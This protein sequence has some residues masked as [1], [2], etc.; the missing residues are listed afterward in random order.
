MKRS[1]FRILVRALALILTLI[2][3]QRLY[4]L[5]LSQSP[6]FLA[7]QAAPIVM[8]S[9]SADNELF[10]KAY[11]DYSNLDGGPLTM[12]DTTYRNDFTYYGYFDPDWCYTYNSYGSDPDE[13]FIPANVTT[14][15]ICSATGSSTTVAAWSGNFL[16]WASMTRI[17]I[18]RQVLY[19]GMRSVDGTSSTILERSY[20][21]KDIHA[22]VKVYEGADVGNYTPY[23]DTQ[24]SLCNVSSDTNGHP[25]IRV[26]TGKWRQWA[27]AESVQCQWN[28]A[29]SDSTPSNST[30]CA[31]ENGTCSFTGTRLVAYGASGQYSW[32]T[33]TGSIACNNATFGDPIPGTYKRCYYA[34]SASTSQRPETTHEL[35]EVTARV[36]VCDAA[37]DGLTSDRCQQY[38]ESPATYKPVGVL[39]VHGEGG[40]IKFGLATGSYKANIK[41]GV[42]R[43]A[44]KLFANNDNSSEDEVNLSTGQ[45]SGVDGIVSNIDA[46]RIAGYSFS[47]NN[48]TDCSTHSISIATV[49]GTSR[50]AN[51]A[52]SDWGNPL[53]EIFMETMRYLAGESAPTTAFNVDDST[54]GTSGYYPGI[55]GLDSVGSTWTDPIPADSWCTN[56]SVILLSTGANSFDGD[57]LGNATDLDGISSGGKSLDDFTDDVGEMEFG[58]FSG[59]YF[60]GGTGTE[61]HCTATTLAGLSDVR[62]IC[63]ELPA[64]EGT[65][66]TAGLAYY[67]WTNDF[68]SDRTDTQTLKTYAVDL[69]ESLPS[70]SIPIGSG[71]IS[72]LPACEA[73]PGSSTTW[74]G[75]SLID[76]EVKNLVYSGGQ[77]VAGSYIFYWEDS[78][79]GNDYDIDGAQWVGFCVGPTACG[80]AGMAAD[81][82]EI[83]SMVPYAYAGND[84][85]FN[86]SVTGSTSDGMGVAWAVR[87]GGTNYNALSNFGSIP[88]NVDSLSATYKVGTSAATLLNKPL[89]YA[90]KY[91]GFNDE[92]GDGTPNH[93]SGDSREWDSVNNSTGASTPDGIPDNYFSVSNPAQLE[94]SLE[95]VLTS[96]VGDVASGSA[97]AANS[98]RL[99]EGTVIYQAKFS[100]TD[101]SGELL[102]MNLDESDGSIEDVEWSTSSNTINPSTRKVYTYNGTAGLE[103]KE[104]NWNSLSVDQR[105]ALQDGSTEAVGKE[106][107]N[108]VRGENVTGYR[109]RETWLGDIVNSDPV[110]AGSKKYGFQYLPDSLG[111]DEYLDY[112]NGTGDYSGAGKKNRRDVVYVS[113]NDGMLHAFDADDGEELFTYIP[114]MVYEGLRNITSVNYGTGANPHQYVVDGPVFVGDAFINGEWKNILVGTLG[115]GGKGVFVLD[116]TDPDSVNASNLVL[117]EL[118]ENDYPEL[119]NVLGKP[120]LA[121]LKDAWKLILGNG[122]NSTDEDAQLL[123]VDLYEPMNVGGNNDPSDVINVGDSGVSNGLA[124]PALLTDSTGVVVA[125]YA[126]DLAG[127]MWK[128][129]LDG[130]KASQW[131]EDYL[132]YTARDDSDNI[133]PITSSPTLGVNAEL[134]NSTMVYFGTGKYFLSSD[135]NDTTTVQSFYAIAD[136]GSNVSST[137]ANRTND[138]HEKT[139]ATQTGGVRTVSGE[140][141]ATGGVTS[142]AVNWATKEGWF[143]DFIAPSSASEGERVISKPLLVFD[144]LIFPTLIPSDAACEFGGSG[145]LMELVAVGDRYT[146]HSILGES[147][148]ELADAVLSVSTLI[149]SGENIYLPTSDIRGNLGKVDGELPD[150]TFGR[151]SWRQLR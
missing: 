34:D 129:D 30:H 125:G 5:D 85:R 106:R 113:A 105:S 92:D 54:A 130:T 45:F 35:T 86:V 123:I 145:W 11:N 87:P 115:A 32:R 59:S 148:K 25:E 64:L 147:G 151:M 69:A 97:A 95:N 107:L 57:D 77:L 71:E 150:G 117:F 134:N 44:A 67:G 2:S 127:K 128:F 132:L 58:T 99:T 18:V 75:C 108:W 19:G 10:K 138:L 61:R 88:S 43:K 100:S 84:L 55:S 51:R 104:S 74:Q 76:V 56:C 135:N 22:F 80:D 48:Y 9:M 79:W 116:V 60:N 142:S 7:Q 82:M 16:N 38:G 39:Q 47:S 24:V 28:S 8:L 14:N 146:D 41:G 42:L 73:K 110:Y 68:R 26:A 31:N 65:Y 94:E 52:C 37:K 93:S 63:P 36:L 141:Q 120:I 40:A 46:L 126:G 144:R 1:S 109:E 4:A 96:I 131:G 103:F 149:R 17:D 118:T 102:A 21:P 137:G 15:H 114:S 62:G 12:A 13:Y 6:L 133:Q 33:A 89:Y 101:W 91:G 119:G 66:A 78:L 143:I 50:A 20:L 81:E 90:A 124:E 140:W 122:Y 139:I 72:F 53:G 70:F 49:K 121:P 3:T 27:A 23:S 111:G 29:S 83:Q 136:Q 98:T 112:I